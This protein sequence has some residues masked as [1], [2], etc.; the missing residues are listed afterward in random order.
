[1]A[2]RTLQREFI[3]SPFEDGA[4]ASR[5]IDSNG[6]SA[7]DR[8]AVYRNNAF[9]NYREALADIYPVVLK[10]VGEAFLPS[11]PAD[12]FANT[13]PEAAISVTMA[14][15]SRRS[16]RGCP[17]QEVCHICTVW[18]ALNGPSIVSFMPRAPRL[19]LGR[20]AQLDPD[21]Q[22]ALRLILNPAA[23]L[24]ASD[25]PILRIWEVSQDGFEGDQQ[26]ALDAGSDL[27]GLMQ[28]PNFTVTI[29]R[30]NPGEYA[31]LSACANDAT[32]IVALGAAMEA[33]SN[34]D[35][36]KS[37]RAHIEKGWIADFRLV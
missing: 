10:L 29:E 19:D 36:Q 30:L 3:Q 15:S 22:S 26:V 34:F 8:L 27:L 20:I 2:L 28:E 24:I 32:L 35:L 31:F 12:S 23:C 37:L 1:M 5:L 16:C 14:Q 17:K 11:Q 25:Y 13:A 18:R 21:D 6:A 7:A 33:D 4:I 9:N